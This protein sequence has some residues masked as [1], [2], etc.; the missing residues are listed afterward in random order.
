PGAKD[1]R[2]WCSETRGFGVRMTPTGKLSFIVQGRVKGTEV[3]V[4]LKIGAY[5][6]WTP[7][8]AR[9]V[10]KEHL[11][12]MDLGIDPR[13]A[14]KADAAMKTTLQE[15]CD[16]YLDR[17]GKLKESS[18]IELRR[19][20]EKVFESWKDRPIVAITEDEVRK[21][22]RELVEHGLRGKKAA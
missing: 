18:R 4:Q 12:S 5:G 10:A 13:L 7:D 1:K 11:R 19:H 20:V 16:A 15:V 8:E 22:H 17:P 9:A 21:R 14:M 6:T 3:S 2:V